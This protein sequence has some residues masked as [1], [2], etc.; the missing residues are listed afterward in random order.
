MAASS[1][2]DTDIYKLMALSLFLL[3]HLCLLQKV[4][5]VTP[6]SSHSVILTPNVEVQVLRVV[7]YEQDIF[8]TT[9]GNYV[10]RVVVTVKCYVHAQ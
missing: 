1:S 10:K 7:K 2:K 5:H 6:C 3:P 9:L 4:S 8:R